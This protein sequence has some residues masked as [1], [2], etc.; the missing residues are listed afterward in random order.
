MVRTVIQTRQ[1]LTHLRG[2][3]KECALPTV[4]WRFR[5][6]LQRYLA[7]PR[8]E[9]FRHRTYVL[10][11]DGLW[12]RFGREDW[13][14][15]VMAVKPVTQRYALFLD[16]VLLQGKESYRRWQQAI[17]T[18]P[19]RL[20]QRIKSLV[21]DGFRGSKRITREHGWVQQRCHFHL[22]AQ[23]QVRR[24]RRKTTLSG[25]KVREAIYQTIHEA[26]EITDEERLMRLTRRL[27]RLAVNPQCPER[28]AMMVHEFLAELPAFRAYQA[29]PD[30]KLPTTT[31]TLEAMNKIIRA[32][33]R[34]INTPPSLLKWATAT[35]RIRR[36]LTCNGKNYQQN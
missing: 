24:G 12:F 17:S 16:P 19:P 23:L 22:L 30:L 5:Q 33:C 21:S 14:L 6:A 10:I 27:H 4:R 11:G 20:S 28:F 26:L 1:S 7:V 9:T 32:T 3:Y 29:Y 25:R 18:I 31:G 35:I 15:Y 34:T 13:V 36:I 8:N 2:R